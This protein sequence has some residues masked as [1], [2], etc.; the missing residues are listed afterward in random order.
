VTFSVLLACWRAGD[1]ESSDQL[2]QTSALVLAV[3]L[4]NDRCSEL[5]GV[6]P[7]DHD[8][9]E[10]LWSDGKW[11]WG[12]LDVYGAQGYSAFVTFDRRGEDRSVEVF[13]ST[14]KVSPLR[15]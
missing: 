15:P 2:N 1:G 10:I 8:S 9:Y 7:F 11:R 4:A 13:Y 3:T 12:G 5:Y 14:D 6:R